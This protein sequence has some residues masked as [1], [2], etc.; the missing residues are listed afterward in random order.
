MGTVTSV[1]VTAKDYSSDGRLSSLCMSLLQ[2]T[3]VTGGFY[4]SL[5]CYH[6]SDA[7]LATGQMLVAT[8]AY[9]P[10]PQCPFVVVTLAPHRF[11]LLSDGADQGPSATV[12]SYNWLTKDT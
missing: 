2:T 5:L 10:L 11:A 12:C 8:V 7:V 3:S 9:G 6:Y 1:P 4:P